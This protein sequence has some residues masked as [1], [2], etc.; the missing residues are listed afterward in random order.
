MTGLNSPWGNRAELLKLFGWSYDYLLWG[1]SWNNVQIML[2]D[3]TRTKPIPEEEKGED[4]LPKPKGGKIVHRE[5][6]TKDDI[7]N[8][9]KGLI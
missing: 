2:A 7:K 4:G 9:V 3:M 8:Y 6:K 5:L 1:I